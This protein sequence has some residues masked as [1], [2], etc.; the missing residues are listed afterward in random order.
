[1]PSSKAPTRLAWEDRFTR[2]SLDELKG[3][4]NKQLAGMFEAAR[5]RLRE[6]EGVEEQL[7]WMGLPW[8]WTLRYAIE[9][10][11]TDAWVYLVPDPLGVEVT[12][13]LTMQMIDSMPTK[14]LK[15]HVRD[16]ITFGK[17]VGEV[18][19]ASWQPAT[20]GPLDEVLDV[21]KRKHKYLAELRASVNA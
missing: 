5:S 7:T 1:M 16:G 8:R 11:P 13:P 9:G 12:I 15:K 6:F 2:P 17:R 14:R 10:D 3:H 20:K 21:A 18:T 4:Y 19:W